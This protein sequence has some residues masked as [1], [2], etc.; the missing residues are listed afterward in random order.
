[1]DRR[2]FLA[3]AVIFMLGCEGRRERTAQPKL[4]RFV[5]VDKSR[6]IVTIVLDLSGSFQGAMADN[7]LAYAFAL[8]VLDKYFRTNIDSPHDRLILAQV[9]GTRKSIM[10]EGTPFDFRRQ[11]DRSSFRAFLQ[12][13]ADPNGSLVYSSIAH[14]LEYL[15]RIATIR[16]G[17]AKSAVLILSDFLENGPDQEKEAKRLLDDLV[18][19]DK[20]GG[21]AGMYY[22]DQ[23]EYGKWRPLLDGVGLTEFI[24][25][26]DFKGHPTLPDFQ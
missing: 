13:K 19:Y 15:M 1:M 24:V 22:V 26:C 9:G 3:G 8:D 7:G 16:D 20:L 14:T 17:K 11:F 23:L 10:W 4:A 5:P 12:Q 25:E 18:A 2:L 6:R 21:V